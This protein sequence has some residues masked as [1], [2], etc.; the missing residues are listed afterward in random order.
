MSDNEKDIPWFHLPF[1]RSLSEQILLMGAPKS[2]LIINGLIMLLFIVDFHFW[3]IIPMNLLVHF[4][5]IYLAKNDAQFFD[6]LRGYIH[7]K[8]YYCT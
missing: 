7:K 2:V 8:K 1:Y 4:G 6:C 5:C 3:Y